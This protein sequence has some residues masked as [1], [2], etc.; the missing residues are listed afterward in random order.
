MNNN[1]PKSASNITFLS[2]ANPLTTQN[3]LYMEGVGQ[4]PVNYGLT[5]KSKLMLDKP[6]PTRLPLEDSLLKLNSEGMQRAWTL[7]TSFAKRHVYDVLNSPVI[8]DPIQWQ[9]KSTTFER[10]TN[11]ITKCAD[12]AR[13]MLEKTKNS[14]LTVKEQARQ[15]EQNALQE[16]KQG[17]S[18]EIKESHSPLHTVYNQDY[19]E[20]IPEPLITPSY[21]NCPL[22]ASQQV[23]ELESSAFP[24]ITITPSDFSDDISPPPTRKP[25]PPSVRKNVAPDQTFLTVE[26][27]Q[28]LKDHIPDPPRILPPL[29]PPSLPT[30]LP[31]PPSFLAPHPPPP[32]LPAPP[33]PPTP[34]PPPLT[35]P[36]P[37]QLL[38]P[39]HSQHSLSSLCPIPLFTAKDKLSPLK[40]PTSEA[41]HP[42]TGPRR[43]L[44][45]ILKNIHNLADIEKSVANMYSQI[46][47][48]S[49]TAK[50]TSKATPLAVADIQSAE[51]VSHHEKPNGI[52]GC[53]AEELEKRFP[54]QSTAL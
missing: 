21:Y 15:F 14:K 16:V 3:P 19:I 23:A 1:L 43:E 12:Y 39:S 51:T 35:P 41:S 49:A 13:S 18:C 50:Q 47:K 36:L 11:E 37:Q 6:S 32:S 53:V 38:T 54:S 33:P 26:S 9:Q 48:N 29:P 24:S 30:P 7:P 28:I 40:L 42:D 22:P 5:W 27:D 46:D 20:K 4:G 34:L 44:K 45:G 17:K 25:T 10:E 52:L 8:M 31:P 2:D